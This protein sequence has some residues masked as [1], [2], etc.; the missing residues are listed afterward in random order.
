MTVSKENIR[1]SIIIGTNSF[2]GNKVDWQTL[3]DVENSDARKKLNLLQT[4]KCV[5]PTK[6]TEA[7]LGIQNLKATKC[8]NFNVD[9]L[10]NST[11]CHCMFPKGTY[12][13][14]I[15]RRISSMEEELVSILIQWESEIFRRF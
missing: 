15:N 14:N 3:N 10:D 5:N 12:D 7:L 6:F 11:V 13:I 9:E 4:I 1:K 8:T 2:V